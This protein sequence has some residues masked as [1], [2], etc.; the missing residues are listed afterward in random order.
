MCLYFIYIRYFTSGGP[1]K[2]CVGN[3][4]HWSGKYNSPFY[5]CFIS[6]FFLLLLMPQGSVPTVL[7]LKFGAAN[8][9]DPGPLKI[10]PTHAGMKS[11][12]EWF[13]L[14]ECFRLTRTFV[15]LGVNLVPRSWSRIS[16]DPLEVWIFIKKS[17]YEVCFW[18]S[19]SIKK[20][21]K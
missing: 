16:S 3:L 9:T 5:F 15:P 1:L 10:W 14:Q 19:C 11:R 13:C 8:F 4:N 17:K 21:R 18:I 12:V 6:L 2:I 20:I 7:I